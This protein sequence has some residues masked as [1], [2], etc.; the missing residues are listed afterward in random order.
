M[1]YLCM[2]LTFI[3][4]GTAG[5]VAMSMMFVAKDADRRI[6]T[7]NCNKANCHGGC[8]GWNV[9]EEKW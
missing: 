5:V 1:I 9:C 6:Q 3:V 8:K 2:F 7:E 4:G